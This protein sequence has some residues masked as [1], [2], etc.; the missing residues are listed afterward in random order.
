MPSNTEGLPVQKKYEIYHDL[1]KLHI[2]T[3]ET[4]RRVAD[5]LPQDPLEEEMLKLIG[6]APADK[7]MEA[8]RAVRRVILAR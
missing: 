2:T 6:D 8:L 7:R 1:L 5:N 3:M 4:L